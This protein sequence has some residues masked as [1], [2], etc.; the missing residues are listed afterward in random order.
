MNNP[1]DKFY[2]TKD[3]QKLERGITWALAM[4][5]IMVAVGVLAWTVFVDPLPM[6][7][8]ST[9]RNECVK[10]EIYNDKSETWEDCGCESIPEKY[11]RIPVK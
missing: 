8:W 2:M 7:S 5:S 3:M 9:S 10:V 4:V 11:E 1:V 6:V